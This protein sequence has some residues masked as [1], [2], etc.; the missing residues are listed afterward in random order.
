MWAR[1]LTVCRCMRDSRSICS[2]WRRRLRPLLIGLSPASTRFSSARHRRPTKRCWTLW[3]AAVRRWA[4]HPIQQCNN[5]VRLRIG[6]Y[7]RDPPSIRQVRQ[8]T[9]LFLPS[10]SVYLNITN[11]LLWKHNEYGLSSS[12]ALPT[13]E[14]RIPRARRTADSCDTCY[15]VQQCDT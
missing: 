11:H 2:H 10:Y 13:R 6:L 5:R 8:H 9:W 7:R 15:G 12:D 3:T 4:S 1:K 14:C